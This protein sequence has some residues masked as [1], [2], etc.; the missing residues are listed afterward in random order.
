MIR[1]RTAGILTALMALAGA[2]PT[3]LAQEALRLPRI[4]E[5]PTA[6]RIWMYALF[7]LLLA[8]IVFASSLKS[9]RTHQD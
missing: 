4:D 1:T 2:A 9:K 6:P 8:V 3:A 7:V 5:S